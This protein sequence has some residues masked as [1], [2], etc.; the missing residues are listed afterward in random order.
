M[1]MA[2]SKKTDPL[3]PSPSLLCKLGSLAVHVDEFL[4][5]D[6]HHFDKAAISQLLTDAEVTD[7]LSEMG[8]LSLIPVKRQ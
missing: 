1:T 5:P 6:A 7:W 8:K 3:T 4:S 2:K